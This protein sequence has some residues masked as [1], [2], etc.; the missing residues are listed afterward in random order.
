ME[1][2]ALSFSFLRFSYW[3]SMIFCR[4]DEVMSV[5]LCWSPAL[6]I[7]AYNYVAFWIITGLLLTRGV[8]GIENIWPVV[9]MR[10]FR[11]LDLLMQECSRLFVVVYGSG[12][13]GSTCVSINLAYGAIH[14]DG[15]LSISLG[16]I[17]VSIEHYNLLGHYSWPVWTLQSFFKISIEG[18]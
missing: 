9:F 11:A 4:Y 12:H 6:L 17:G 14:F 7:R 18:N 10:L 16:W 3:R 1:L 8:E 13:L 5:H 15:A 2:L